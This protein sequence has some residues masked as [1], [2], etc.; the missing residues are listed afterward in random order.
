L[1][2]LRVVFNKPRVVA[3]VGQGRCWYPDII[4][5]ST[6]ELMLNYSLNADTNENEHNSQAV[7][8]STDG[9]RTFDFTYDV[10]GFHNGGG[11]PRIS[12]E[13]GRIVG[14]ST[15]LKPAPKGQ[16]RCFLAHRWTYDH[17]G[18]CCTVEPWGA[19]VEGLPREVA[20]YPKVSR[21]W[22]C[23]INWFSDIL[24]VADGFWISTLS[25]RYGGDQ[26]ETTVALISENEGRLWRY[27]STIAGADAVPDAKEGFDEP[28]LV[29]LENGNLMCVSRV[30]SRQPLARS[31]SSDGGKSWSALDRLP[32]YSV[33]PQL[34]RTRSGTLV[35]STGRP[36]VFL[37]FS[38]DP[39][40]ENWQS[41][42]VLAHHN[43][44][45]DAASQMEAKQTTAYTAMVEVEDDRIFLV[46]DRTPFAW[47][48]VPAGSGERA[49][50]LLLE[51]SVK[52][53]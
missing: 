44:T 27:L 35:L 40:G 12:L 53:Q 23:R 9:G 41:I 19:L 32:A 20:P 3:E 24:L 4:K 30:G 29:Q 18:R 1:N 13:D 15:F 7:H 16:G 14:A 43:S 48:P 8:I 2:G 5:F 37:W 45:L 36:G 21:T 10:N 42:D 28:C 38:T 39:R 33:A 6:G 26:R 51:F 46:Y 31:Y 47:E 34:C 49:Q 17:G 50:I 22:W 52:R 11:E 25:L